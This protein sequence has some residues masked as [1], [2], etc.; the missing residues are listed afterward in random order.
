[1]PIPKLA[2]VTDIGHI[3]EFPLVNE[4]LKVEDFPRLQKGISSTSIFGLL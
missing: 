4:G 3:K 1:M 2:M